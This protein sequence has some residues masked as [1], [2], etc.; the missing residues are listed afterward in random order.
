MGLGKTC[1]TIGFIKQIHGLHFI[2]CPL[3]V[4]DNW[5]K[6]LKKFWSNTLPLF[7]L[8]GGKE[9]RKQLKLKFSPSKY[10]VLLTTYEIYLKDEEFFNN[11][12]FQYDFFI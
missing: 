10:R 3:S 6:E 12:N 2:L 5:K 11:I 8:V 4:M 7:C 9:K 1:Q